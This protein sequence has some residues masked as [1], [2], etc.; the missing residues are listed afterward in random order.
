M[1]VGPPARPMELATR[2]TTHPGLDVTRRHVG[3]RDGRHLAERGAVLSCKRDGAFRSAHDTPPQL[4]RT[5]TIPGAGNH[6]ALRRAWPK[7][8]GNPRAPAD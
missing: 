4:V 8:E 7:N 5:Q 3:S 1:S 6:G 2:D